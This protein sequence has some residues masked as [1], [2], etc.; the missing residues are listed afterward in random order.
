MRWLLRKSAKQLD[1]M[2]SGLR[3]RSPSLCDPE[4][5]GRMPSK[6]VQVDQSSC[7]DVTNRPGIM[8]DNCR[9]KALQG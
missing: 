9:I 7:V 2:H 5:T 1:W 3:K 4:S 6:I 8:S